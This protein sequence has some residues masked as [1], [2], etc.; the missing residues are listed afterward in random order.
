MK[1]HLALVA[2]VLALL[3]AS[4]GDAH[5]QASVATAEVL[6]QEGVKQLEAGHL[7]VACT[8]LRDS[9]K[10]DPANG[11][12]LALAS[13][14]ERRGRLA[15]AWGLYKVALG[16]VAPTDK[17]IPAVNERIA[18]IEPRL[19]RVVVKLD[20]GAPAG[21]KVR[22]GDAEVLAST[23]GVAVPV[24]PGE[25]VYTV[26]A[27]GYEAAT[28]KVQAAEK[29]TADV[30]AK[31]GAKK[32]AAAVAALPV[33][34][35][36][37]QRAAKPVAPPPTPASAP[38][39]DRTAGWVVGGAGLA[40][41]GAGVV[42]YVLATQK[43]AVAEDNCNAD[44]ARCN[45]TGKSADDSIKTLNVV[46]I[47]TLGLGAVGLGVGSWLLFKPSAESTARVQTGPVVMAGGPGWGVGGAW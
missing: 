24:D 46:T 39:T 40:L 12:K 3:L 1:T 18:A 28:V 23:F 19:A 45:A 8:K 21:T 35:S 20:P 31:P 10:L 22:E 25:H 14:E 17:R 41:A 33:A 27:E 13:C 44:L 7:D 36:P 38:P 6:F 11:T 47:A 2:P 37:A 4:G 43:R 5:G 26:E 9:D 42:S 30:L 15:T 32:A 16:R 34:P 29:K